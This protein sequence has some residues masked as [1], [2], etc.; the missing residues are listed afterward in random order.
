WLGHLN[1]KSCGD[2][3]RQY[4]GHVSEHGN[5][6][7]AYRRGLHARE[8]ETKRTNNVRLLDIALTIK[9]QRSL[10]VVFREFLGITANLVVGDAF[11]ERHEALL[12]SLERTP[13]A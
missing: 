11:W 5:N 7:F 12:A 2:A 4:I 10:I 1:S 6:S 13:T 8:L 3:A 9:K